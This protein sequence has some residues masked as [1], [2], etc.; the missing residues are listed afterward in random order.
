MILILEVCKTAEMK[1]FLESPVIV[2]SKKISILTAIFGDNV[3][4]VTLSLMEL[5]VNNGRESLLPAVARVFISETKKHKGITESVLTTAVKVNDNVRNEIIALISDV[6]K[7]KVDLREIIDPEITGGFILRIDDNY[8]DG[9]IRSKLRKIRKE[10]T[11][12]V[13]AS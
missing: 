6:F 2:P 5:I 12:S 11:G 10:L 3:Q 8:I 9:S 1:E 7:T 13:A 4:A